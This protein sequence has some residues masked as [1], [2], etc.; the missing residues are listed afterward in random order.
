MGSALNSTSALGSPVATDVAS[1]RSVGPSVRADREQDETT[2]VGVTAV[3]F[4]SLL[5][6]ARISAGTER[7]GRAERSFASQIFEPAEPASGGDRRQSVEQANASGV[8]GVDRLDRTSVDARR[9]ASEERGGASA[10]KTAPE[11]LTLATDRRSTE[12]TE[13]RQ[14]VARSTVLD[15]NTLDEGFRNTTTK[16]STKTDLRPAFE[17]TSNAKSSPVVAGLEA[18]SRASASAAATGAPRVAASSNATG[19]TLAGQVGRVLSTPPANGPT[20]NAVASP[21]SPRNMPDAN[22]KKGT[23]TQTQPGRDSGTSGGGRAGE[24][25]AAESSPFDELVRSIRLQQTANGSSARLTLDPPDLGKIQV[26]V[27]LRNN[28]MTISVRTESSIAKT[29]M[30]ER[31]SVLTKSL[32]EQGIH[33]DQLD[34]TTELVADESYDAADGGQGDA[35]AMHDQASAFSPK[36]TRAAAALMA[37]PEHAATPI[38]DAVME[39][40]SE[41]RLDIRI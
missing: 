9:T 23:P 35:T 14:P 18:P 30:V 19:K 36:P 27:R 12:P 7:S 21:S 17:P 24:A 13:Q 34:V 25:S 10:D 39:V 3:A 6:V 28:R 37:E 40:A 33:V 41:T 2:D 26:D 32:E 15:R 1:R 31:A 11:R 5:T 22:S 29:L 4:E 16:T 8:D 38:V 20:G